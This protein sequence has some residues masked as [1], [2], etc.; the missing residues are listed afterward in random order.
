MQ[1][2]GG[3]RALSSW[4][5][6]KKEAATATM[7]IPRKKDLLTLQEQYK[8]D[9][10]I[11]EA[12]G[13]V[14]EY[15]VGYWRRKKGI[16]VYSAPK[17]SQT[18]IEEAWLR[19]GDDFKA[20]RELNLSKAAFYSWR[21]KYGIT[22]KPEHLKLEQLE[23][24]FNAAVGTG[25][26]LGGERSTLPA[27]TT[28]KLWRRMAENSPTAELL[29]DWYLR[30]HNKPDGKDRLFELA[31]GNGGSAEPAVPEYVDP[32]I[33]R[34]S[35]YHSVWGD[36]DYGRAD[37]QLIEGRV[38]RPGETLAGDAPDLG[39]LGGIAVLW[40]P[41]NMAQ[42]A[43]ICKVEFARH[44][45]MRADVEDRFL[46]FLR[47][48]PHREWKGCVLEFEGAAVERMT[49][50]RKIKLSQ[51]A[52]YFGAAAALCPFDDVM[53]KHYPR[54]MKARFIKAF[55]DHGAVY[56]Q[57]F[58]LESRLKDVHLGVYDGGW[59]GLRGKEAA[60]QRVQTIIIGPDALPYEIAYAAETLDGHRLPRS[61]SVIVMPI[62]AGTVCDSHRRGWLEHLVSAGASIVDPRLAAR[63]GLQTAV[64]TEEGNIL[65]TRPP[66]NPG[67]LASDRR[68]L[69]FAGVRT[70]AAS[71]I[72]GK[73]TLP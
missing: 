33:T 30:D 24:R 21:R 14:P 55:P 28:L 62:S 37:W 18:E 9:K 68:R 1:Q 59:Q 38:I 65:F 17:F 10:K 39:G 61:V 29:P 15:L 52:T 2:R 57:E 58:L 45:G 27:P 8:T 60:G 42:P 41:E 64:G 50:D 54:N 31:P 11:A 53:R 12:L 48:Y 25:S 67:Q 5:G 43:G 23:L 16:P 22:E 6:E 63:I 70:A 47:R 40:L 46:D 19:H 13:G 44:A 7:K 34:P 51:L 66:E 72:R 56:D 32:T 49:V 20:G 36:R 69:W 26:L 4:R 3:R 73:V 35:G 71:A